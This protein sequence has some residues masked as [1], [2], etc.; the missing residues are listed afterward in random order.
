MDPTGAPYDKHWA[1]ILPKKPDIKAPFFP[2]WELNEIDWFIGQKIHQNGW[3]PSQSADKETLLRRVYFDV[4]GLPPS[5]E[6]IDAF[7]ADES[8]NA[9]EKGIIYLRNHQ[10]P[11]H[12]LILI[13]WFYFRIPMFCF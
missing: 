1:Y 9:Y 7:L 3:Q 2:R 6:E 10:P 4:I 8:E 11:F 13:Y 5:I 12:Y